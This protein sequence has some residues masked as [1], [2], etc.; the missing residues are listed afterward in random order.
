METN[1]RIRF[2]NKTFSSG[3]ICKRFHWNAVHYCFY[4]DSCVSTSITFGNPADPTDNTFVPR[5]D[6]YF[7]FLF[8]TLTYFQGHTE[9]FGTFI[10]PN[11]AILALLFLPFYDRNPYRNPGKRLFALVMI[12]LGIIG[13]AYLTHAAIEGTPKIPSW[14]PAHGM[15]P[16]RA[17]R[18]KRPSEVGG[19]SV[20]QEYCFGCHSMTVLGPKPSLQMLA[21]KSFPIGKDWLQDHLKRSG[22]E[23][24]LTKKDSEML[25]SALRVTAGDRPDLALYDPAACS[26]WR[27]I[28]LQRTMY[29]LS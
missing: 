5:P 7:L 22:K 11:L 29:L 1:R 12:V 21:R 6:W 9:I 13:W 19:M 14:H 23:I 16:P 24:L 18:I 2:T 27:T 26:S 10:L 15:E 3:A 28:V 25:M 20:L 17:E 8:Q 4:F